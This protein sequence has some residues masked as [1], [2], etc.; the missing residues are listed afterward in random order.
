MLLV[1]PRLYV[2]LSSYDRA[3]AR[4]CVDH[5][6]PKKSARKK[7]SMAPEMLSEDFKLFTLFTFYIAP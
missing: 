7:E 5:L 4:K 1:T 6:E 2:D 3:I